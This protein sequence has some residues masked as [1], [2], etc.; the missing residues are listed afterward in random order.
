MAITISGENNNDKILAQDGVIDTISGF[1]I[2]G[3]ITASSFTGDL[4]GDVTGN[5]TGNVNATSNLLLQIGGSEKFRVAS[6]G[7]LGI[8]G[9]NYGTSGQ[10]LTSGG[11]GSAATWSAIPSQVTINNA[12]GNRVIT[13]DG[14][15][16][17]N[18]EANLTFTGQTLTAHM[19]T[20]DPAV[21]VGDSNRTGAGQ[22]LAEYRGYWDG[23]HVGRIVFAAGD[24]TTNKDDG[25]IKFHTTPSGGGITERLRI[26]SSGR[27]LIGTTTEGNASADDLTIA[28]SDNAGITIRSGTAHQGGIYFS[29]ATSGNAE[30]DGFIVYDQN[31]REFRFGTQQSTRMRLDS[32]G[33]LGINEVSP[34]RKLHVRSDGAAAAK[35][36]GES[37]AAYYMEIGQLASSG[38]PGFNATGSSTSMLFQLNGSEKVRIASDGRVGINTTLTVMDGVTGN[39]N[40]AND[41]FNNHTVINLSRN[42]A[43]DRAQIRFSNPNGNIGSIN[44]FGSDFAI[45]AA[46]D[47][48]FGASNAEKLRITSGGDVS[49]GGLSSPRAKLDIEDAGTGKDVILRVSAD[50]NNPYAFVVG[51]DAHDATSNRGIAMWI[52]GSR[53]HHIQ[54]RGS[55]TMSDNQLEIEAF[56]I[57]FQTGSSMNQDIFIDANGRLIVGDTANRLAWGI[58]PALQVNGT[59]WDDTCIALHNFGNNTRRPSL[60]FT[61]GR[62]G[63]LGNF[64]TAVN[65]GEG[66]GII[67]W[68][69][70]D[71]TDAENLACYIQGISESAPTTN[72][73]YGAI[74]FST[75]NGGT[76]AYERVRISSDGTV[77]IGQDS[78][79]NVSTRAILELN[80]PYSDVSDNDGS[81]D[82]GTNGHDAL[83]INISGPSAASGKNVGSIA[84]G[85]SRR[86][87]AIMAEYQNTDADFLA[88]AFF[89][90]GTD[91]PNDFYKSFI[92]NHN[93]SAGLHGSLSQNTSDDRLKKDKVEITNALDKVNS[94]SSFTHKWNEIAVRAGLE[95]GKEEIGLSAQEVQGLYPSLVNVNNVMKDPE[96][97]DVDYLTVHY[98]KVVPL[99]VASIKELTA[100]NKALEA[101]LDALEG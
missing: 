18:G 24:D 66:L 34:D 64:G 29:D 49:I 22:H 74:T 96:N 65:A 26:D 58:N 44:T 88:L 81:A 16:T 82:L 61:K 86:R 100:K 48:I 68:S 83:L 63:T 80:A 53:K 97:P 9:A 76:S 8:G 36:G 78:G 1:N 51:N 77:G 38:S 25:I 99:L 33:N 12:S 11:S 32:S 95:E 20:Q 23:N 57:N 87:A 41:N 60:L 50:D 37:G 89:T 72:N 10:V 62:S 91:G 55:S 59:E 7:Q 101:R 54:A 92:I 73:Q 70:H 69:A 30:F 43:A 40:I 19:S 67:G 98:D 94:L 90:R 21:F 56:T 79:G 85:G 17:L 31:D 71:T 75:V 28:G 15:T 84:W 39:L 3:I 27:V 2:A 5:L 42:T 46:N 45:Y 4:T 47:F 13:S 93:G 6:S 52:G 14:G 35:L